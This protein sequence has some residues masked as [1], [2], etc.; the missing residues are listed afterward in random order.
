MKLRV[1][2][3]RSFYFSAIALF[4]IVLSCTQ[5]SYEKG[6]LLI[7]VYYIIIR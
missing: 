3:K 1:T 6:T 7:V 2:I 5:D 4:C